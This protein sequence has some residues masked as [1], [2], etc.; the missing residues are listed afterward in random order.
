LAVEKKAVELAELVKKR[1]YEVDV[2]LVRLGAILHD[3]G[4]SKT[5]GI[6]HGIEGG[7]I[8]RKLGLPKLSKFAENH[9]GAGIP[10][11]EAVKLGLPARDFMPRTI[12]EKIVTYADKLI[13]G[14]QVVEIGQILKRFESELGSTHPAITRL[15]KLHEEVMRMSRGG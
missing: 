8:L 12:E 7:K 3:I 6:K 2:E 1:G 11:E 13:E 15:R 5:H 14:N 9:L 4:R 10:R